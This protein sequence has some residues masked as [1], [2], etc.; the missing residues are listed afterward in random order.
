MK[1]AIIRFLLL[2][3]AVVAVGY[4]LYVRISALQWSANVQVVLSNLFPLFGLAA[5]SL[6]WLHALSGVF[7]PWLRP[8]INF[9]RFISI[10]AILILSCILCHPVLLLMLFSLN[11]NAILVTYGTWYIVLGFVGWCLLMSYDLLKPSAKRGGFW[12]KHWTKV[13][14]VS[15]VGFLITYFHAM[16]LGS[17]LQTGMLRNIWMFYGITAF[18]CIIYTYIIKPMLKRA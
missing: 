14:L 16:G 8:V 13:L 7:E 2:V 6:L 4:P 18:A 17:D 1:N 10:T 12:A 3:F 15:N 5:F 9:D 11:I